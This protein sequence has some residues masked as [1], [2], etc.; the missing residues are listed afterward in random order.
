M[1]DTCIFCNTVKGETKLELIYE[2]KELIAV[3]HPKGAAPGHVI[4]IPKK[5]YQ[6]FEQIPDYEVSHLFNICQSKIYNM[7]KKHKKIYQPE[8]NLSSILADGR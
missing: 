2:D 6:I 5:H 4:V 7:V 1:A 3:M 8:A